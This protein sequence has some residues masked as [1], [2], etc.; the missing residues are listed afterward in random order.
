MDAPSRRVFLSLAMNTI[1]AAAIGASGAQFI[2]VAD[3]M[4][5]DP[6]LSRA[7]RAPGD[8]AIP[9]QWGPPPRPGW[10]PSHPGWGPRLRRRRRWV[11]WWHRGRRHCGWRW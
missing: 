10:G 2:G 11:C 5:V 3:A 8:R 1:A 9:V 7:G 6:G 4:P